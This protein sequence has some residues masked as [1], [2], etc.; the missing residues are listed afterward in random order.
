[1]EALFWVNAWRN[2]GVPEDVIRRF[3]ERYGEPSPELTEALLSDDRNMGIGMLTIPY[4]NPE[5][6][7]HDCEMLLAKMGYPISN[8]AE[9]QGRFFGGTLLRG[10]KGAGFATVAIPI[11][12]LGSV[13]GGVIMIVR[14]MVK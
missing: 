6:A 2:E 10:V 8:I 11:A 4:S 9:T 5:V 12:V 3:Y 14:E 1:M 13:V 7:Q